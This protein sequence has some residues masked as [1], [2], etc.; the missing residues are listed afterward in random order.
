MSSATH[1]DEYRALR[2]AITQRGTARVL[3]QWIGLAAW[4]GLLV[5]VLVWL[6]FPSASL[7]PLVVLAAGFELARGLHLGV[8]RIGRYLQVFHEQDDGP[9]WEHVAMTLGPQV[10]GA[11]GHPLATPLYTLATAVNGLAVALPR[12]VPVEWAIIGGGHVVFIVWMAM[13]DA[14]MR[15]QR[16]EELEALR[17]IKTSG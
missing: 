1:A 7:V 8:E 3:L 10:P 12:A 2:H 15:R 13:C 9:A 17:R 11:G 5:A 14:R 6:P 16:Q 4:G